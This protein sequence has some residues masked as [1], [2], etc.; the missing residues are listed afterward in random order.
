M[1]GFWQIRQ[2]IATKNRRLVRIDK[3]S[4]H[5]KLT[6]LEDR[7]WFSID[8]H[9]KEG[10]HVVAFLTGLRNSHLAE[11]GPCWRRFLGCESWIPHNRFRTRLL[12]EYRPK[13]T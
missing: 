10:S 9:Q 11:S 8:R 12:P 1:I 3:Q 13:R 7:K 2:R 6:R 5:N 4:Q